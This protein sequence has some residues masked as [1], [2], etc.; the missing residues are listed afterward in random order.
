M[1]FCYLCWCG[2]CLR[3]PWSSV[4]WETGIPGPVPWETCLRETSMRGLFDPNGLQLVVWGMKRD[5]GEQVMSD[6][7][8]KDCANPPH[9]GSV[10]MNVPLSGS[11]MSGPRVQPAPYTH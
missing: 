3:V 4:S 10:M 1:D 8:Q 6:H 7:Q 5:K 11:M 9:S 2:V